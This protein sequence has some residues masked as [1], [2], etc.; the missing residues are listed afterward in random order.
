MKPCGRWE[1]HHHA[2][3][4]SALEGG[5]LSDSLEVSFIRMERS[6]NTHW[7]ESG[8]GPSDVLE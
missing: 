8:V 3:L 1:V 2:V 5:E 6:T 7:I 4:S